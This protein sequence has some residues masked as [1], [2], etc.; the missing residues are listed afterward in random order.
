[1]EPHEILALPGRHV[2]LTA[3]RQGRRVRVW[4]QAGE[5]GGVRE[6]V[7]VE[8]ISRL[9][10]EPQTLVWVDLEAPGPAALAALQAECRLHPLAIEDVQQ[11]HQRPKI[12]EYDTFYFIVFYVPFYEAAT[13]HIRVEE[14]SLF[15]GQGYI[16]TVHDGPIQQIEQ[17]VARWRQAVD[18][19]GARHLGALLYSLL[20]SLLDAYFPIVDRIGEELDDLQE[21]LF[22]RADRRTLRRLSLLRRALLRLRRVLA[23][24]RDVINTLL[25]RDRPILPADTVVYFHD[26]YDHVVRLTDT[27]DTHRDMLG[28]VVDAYLSVTSNNLNQIM[29]TLTGWSIILMS[30]SL[31]A[32]IYG[33]NFRL[34][35][36]LEWPYGYPM[37][38]ALIFAVG[39]LLYAYFRRRDWL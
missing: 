14:V 30:G 13:A 28:G 8:E 29:R 11:R 38:V 9:L 17:S 3:L 32:G 5:R 12:D 4:A 20:D 31:V 34:M 6:G 1:M 36:E 35:P 26:L 19:M 25:R 21:V 10:A 37:A 33:M 16:V 15:L 27:I 2:N 22:A 39:L 18:E 7:A 23:P 24:Q